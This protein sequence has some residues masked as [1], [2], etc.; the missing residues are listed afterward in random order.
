[1]SDKPNFMVAMAGILGRPTSTEDWTEED[2]KAHDAR[3]ASDN[4]ALA[5][6][7]TRSAV[8]QLADLDWPRK[9]LLSA[10]KHKVA[11]GV[12]D[13]KF[14]SQNITVLAGPPGVG[15]TVTAAAWAVHSPARPRFL[16]ASALAAA[17]RYSQD[18]RAKW[19]ETRSLVLDD[20]GDEYTD[21]AGSFLVDLDELVDTYYSDL[22]TLVI[23]TN[24]G[25]EEFASRYGVR[26]ADRLRESGRWITMTGPSRRGQP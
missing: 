21:K 15:K 8:S 13:G 4:L 10:S 16:R 14:P 20:L 24:L 23:T 19:M 11:L 6:Q 22:R 12:F 9:V 18:A 3:C 17:S 7:D 26:I 5:E 1:M 2:W 25:R